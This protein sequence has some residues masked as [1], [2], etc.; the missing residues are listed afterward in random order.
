MRTLRAAAAAGRGTLLSPGLAEMLAR[1][2]AEVPFGKAATLVQDLAGIT[3]NA[4][5]VERPAEASGAAARNA[6]AAEAAL[7]RARTARPLPPPEPVPDMLYAGAGGTG[8]PVRA[9]ETEGRPGKNEDGKAGT[10]E[11]K[12]ARLFTVSRPGS[13][14]YPVMDPGSPACV[15]AFDGKT[16][17]AE[18]AGDRVPA[19]RRRAFPPGRGDRR[20]RGVDLD[21]GRSA[22]PARQGAASII[23]LR[24][25]HASGRWDELWP[26]GSPSPARLRTAI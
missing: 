2:G 22:L 11:I 3:V 7:L 5:T 12:L 25:Q 10:R 4:R 17:L 21:H 16:A 6:G 8:V 23:T 26:D 24:C 14:G 9:S 19:P 15:A 1:A 13:D 20:R 18:L